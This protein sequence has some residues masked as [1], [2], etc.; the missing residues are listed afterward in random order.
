MSDRGTLL[1][2][3]C[4]DLRRRLQQTSLARGIKTMHSML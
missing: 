1:P 2:A 4:T 3:T